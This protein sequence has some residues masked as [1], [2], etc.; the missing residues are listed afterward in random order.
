MWVTSMW[1]IDKLKY[2]LAPA[3]T[4]GETE[5]A[6]DSVLGRWAVGEHFVSGAYLSDYLQILHTAPLGGSS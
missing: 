1:I 5:G 4:V 6:M 2:F 3:V